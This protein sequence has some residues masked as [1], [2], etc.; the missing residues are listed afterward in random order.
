[1]WVC[2]CVWEGVYGLV[3]VCVGVG[4]CL[5]M[6]ICV[7]LLLSMFFPV[8][9]ALAEQLVSEVKRLQQELAVTKSK[10]QSAG[11]VIA[12]M[13]SEGLSL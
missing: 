6:Y 2:R 5:C 9:L 10:L 1:M 7:C 11:E 3:E 4:V 13:P 12:K 8:S